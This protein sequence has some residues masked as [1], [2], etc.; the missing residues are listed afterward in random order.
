[1]NRKS[2]YKIVIDF[3][4]SKSSYIYDRSRNKKYLDFFGQ[5]ASLAIGYNHSIFDSKEFINEIKYISK[6]KIVNNEILSIETKNFDK[7]FIKFNSGNNFTYTHYTCTGSL[8]V[9]SAIKT[10]MD[11]KKIK[12]PNIISFKGNFHGINS[13]GGIISDRFGGVSKRLKGFPGNYWY[14]YK[15]PIITYKNNKIYQNLDLVRQILLQIEDKIKKDKNTCCILIEPI[16]CTNGDRYFSNQFFMGIRKIATK[17]DIPLIFDEI[18]TGFCASGKNWY[19]QYT[20]IIPDILI[21]G[22]KTQLSGI[23]VNKKFAKIFKTPIRL[24]VTWDGDVVDMVRCKYIIKAFNKYRVLMNV[25]KM[26]SV[27]EKGL[28]E[29]Q[30]LK[31]IR[32]SGLLFAFDLHKRID[33]NDFSS[34]LFKNEMLCNPTGNNTI[35]LRPHLFTTKKEIDEGL[36][37][38]NDSIKVIAK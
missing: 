21:F 38:I 3:K 33:I 1:L 4:K 9:E 30:F 32:N 11:Y 29:I 2:R 19:Y 25:N 35:R 27:F 22:K 34:K 18:Q 16:Q 28:K 23:M 15:N 12:N 10:A 7:E 6:Q 26:A 14:K 36:N 31:N 8:A 20:H 37:R 13:Y 17:Y 5:Y 24:E